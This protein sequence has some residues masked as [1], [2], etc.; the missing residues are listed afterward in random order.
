MIGCIE[1]NNMLDVG[2]FYVDTTDEIKKLPNMTKCGE[3]ELANMNQ[4]NCGSQCICREDSSV[5]LLAGDNTW[6]LFKSSGGG[7]GGGADWPDGYETED[8]D[9][10][11]WPPN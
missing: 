9:F 5:Y 4:V 10:N 3:E 8:I 6:Q 2:T 11:N 7:G 1:Y